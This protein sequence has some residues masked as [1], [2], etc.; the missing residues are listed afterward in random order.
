M[1]VFVARQPIFDRQRELYGYGLLYRS[2][3]CQSAFDGTDRVTATIQ[4]IANALLAIGL[5][6]LLS[7]KKAFINFD[8]S[9]LLGGLHSV[10]PPEILVIEIL[11]SV[12]ADAEV[13]ALCRKLREQGYVFA[14][15][16]FVPD[17]RR[18]A[19]ARMAQLIKV[20]LTATPRADQEGGVTCWARMWRARSSR[21]G[22]P[23][24]RT[25][26]T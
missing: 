16:D 7:N 17:S 9:L 18:E 24:P 23:A 6:N 15:S 26:R 21:P 1:D 2:E 8:R 13:L 12:E 25:R 4:V 14:L 22:A 5:E 20:D 11:E 3:A 10:L 19:L